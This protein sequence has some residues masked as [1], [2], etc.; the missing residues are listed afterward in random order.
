MYKAYCHVVP[1]LPDLTTRYWFYMDIAV[2]VG[3]FKRGFKSTCTCM[4]MP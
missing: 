3:T 1:H 4:W 2:G